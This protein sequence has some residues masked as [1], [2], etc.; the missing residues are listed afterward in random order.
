MNSPI[1][2]NIQLDSY[3]FAHEFGVYF[4]PFDFTNNI[5]CR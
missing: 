1:L 2:S 4:D 5:R 3:E